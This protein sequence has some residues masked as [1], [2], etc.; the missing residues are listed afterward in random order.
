MKEVEVVKEVNQFGVDCGTVKKLV[1]QAGKMKK[2]IRHIK[3]IV[4][5]LEKEKGK[6]G[7]QV[8]NG[9]TRVDISSKKCPVC[10]KEFVSIP[11]CR[12]H[13]EH[14]HIGKSNGFDCEICGRKLSNKQNLLR[15]L[16]TH[17]KNVQSCQKCGKQFGSLQALNN[18][19]ANHKRMESG[20]EEQLR[21]PHC[22]K[23][24]ARTMKKV[25]L[26]VVGGSTS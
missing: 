18:H 25:Q 19:E 15:H 7:V 26:C 9:I 11:S 17:E 20:D 21:C 2:E 12:N 16:R 10:N 4:E 3:H 23:I 22:K 1:D 8:E 5:K 14:L 24:P 6:S 13:Y